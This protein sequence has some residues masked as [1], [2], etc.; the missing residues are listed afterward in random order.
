MDREKLIKTLILQVKDVWHEG[1]N[2]S[3][4]EGS[5]FQTGNV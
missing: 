5:Y 2:R 1:N 3:I 4:G